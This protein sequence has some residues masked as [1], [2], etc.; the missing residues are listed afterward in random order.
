MEGQSHVALM[1]GDFNPSLVARIEE[2]GNESDR[3]EGASGDDQDAA[4][5]KHPRRKKYHR[6]TP[7]QIQEL[8]AYFKMNNHPDEKERLEL[9]KRLSLESKQIK[10]WFQNRRTQMKTQTERHENNYLKR[11]N[12]ELLI[13]NIRMKE[14]M[15]NPMC[16]NCG[17]PA[18]LGEVSIE[19]HHLR[20]ENARLKEELNRIS[21]LAN[22]FLGRP[23]SSFAGLVHPPM[24]NTSL[25]LAVG[26]NGFSGLSSVNTTF[27]IGLDSKDGILNTLPGMPLVPPPPTGIARNEPF[28]KSIFLELALRAMDELVKLAQMDDP[29]WIRSLD[30]GREVLNEEEY[31]KICPP[32]IGMKPTGFVIEATKA[33]GMVLANSLNLVETLMDANQ[34]AEMFPC[35]VGRS[36]IID[37]IF[38]GM[39]GSRNCVLQLMHAEFQ[40]L[41]PL[42]PVRHVK[43]LR[44]CKQHAERVWAVVDVSVDGIREVSDAHTFVN[45]RRLPSGCIVEDMPNGFSKVTWVE[46]T[47]YDESITHHLYRPLLSSGMGFGAQRCLAS[48]QRQCEYLAVLM[49]NIST[50]NHSGITPMG[51]TGMVRLAHRMTRS[52]C[53]G[54]CA[55]MNMWQLV[56][57]GNVGE[58]VRLMIR[59][60]VDKPGEPSGL[61]LS[62]STSVWMPVS[63]QRLF[64]FLRDEQLRSEWDELSHGGPM[65]EMLN[66]APGQD[67]GNC[68]SLLRATAAANNTNQNAMLILQET[69][70][71]ASGSLIVYTA[72]DVAAMQVVMNGGDSASVV[73]LPSGFAIVPDGFPDSARPNDCNGNLI[74]GNGGSLLT[75][76][77]QI[78]VNNQSPSAKLTMESVDTINSLITR[79]IQRI[80]AALHCN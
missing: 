78:L 39:A 57:I 48:L 21:A 18:I 44:F 25:E 8:E 30:G 27:P 54:V 38:S 79:T 52:Y 63:H 80:R 20:V 12:E 75:L 7:Y 67:R 66:I 61:V 9:G 43:F 73:L 46:H 28:E 55:T 2:D 26:I 59:K 32:C 35:M 77:F 69:Q 19:K 65:Q 23:I 49:S 22:R 16:C 47:E 56:Q 51:R 6:H 42:V 24:S 68:V 45:C 29:L 3:L 71:D 58:E 11:Q 62:A 40:A 60:S 50:E 17:G 53:A 41:S 13:E 34:W 5:N 76:G 4:G 1:G 10:F 36:S 37:V 64:D 31:M 14:V 72:V 33:T 15:G 74:K 70:S